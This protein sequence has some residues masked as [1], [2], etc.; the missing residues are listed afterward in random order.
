MTQLLVRHID[1]GPTPSQ[2]EHENVLSMSS[3]DIVLVSKVG[4]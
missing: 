4:A 3:P 2:C 1:P